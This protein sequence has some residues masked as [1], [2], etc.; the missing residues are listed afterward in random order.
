MENPSSLCVKISRDWRVPK[1]PQNRFPCHHLRPWLLS[2]VDC[3]NFPEQNEHPGSVLPYEMRSR[4]FC[5]QWA[6]EDAGGK[7]SVH[8]SSRLLSGL[9]AWL[10]LWGRRGVT[11][12]FWAEKLLW[13][14]QALPGSP[15]R[16]GRRRRDHW[17][18]CP[19]PPSD[20]T[21]R[22]LPALCSPGC[23]SSH[24]RSPDLALLTKQP[25]AWSL[26][27]PGVRSPPL[28]P[29]SDA[30]VSLSPSWSKAC[31]TPTPG[32][33]CPLPCLYL[34]LLCIANCSMKCSQQALA[35]GL[36]SQ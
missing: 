24:P 32:T 36:M 27:P 35:T 2:L 25:S 1:F 14:A 8:P 19:S 5:R 16:R 29:S 34:S 23:F 31:P 4:G 20:F 12:E 30:R 28:A 10:S 3:R 6:D 22:G 17:G 21:L 26:Q 11:G 9:W 13:E 15:W 33:S 7:E 18:R